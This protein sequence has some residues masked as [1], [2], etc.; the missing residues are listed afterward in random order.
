MGFIS[1]LKVGE[2][3]E[4]FILKFLNRYYLPKLEKNKERTG[5]DLVDLDT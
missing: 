2:G 4:D 1:D 3:Y 5:V